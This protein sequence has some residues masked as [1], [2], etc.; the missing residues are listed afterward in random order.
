MPQVRS[1]G[2][3]GLF[4]FTLNS[5]M[6]MTLNSSAEIEGAQLSDNDTVL[7]CSDSSTLKTL[8]LTVK[9]GPF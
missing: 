9:G 7:T 3:G 4:A 2:S 8:T 5:Y 6:G 1:S